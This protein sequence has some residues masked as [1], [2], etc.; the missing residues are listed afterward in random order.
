M[1]QIKPA[2][3]APSRGGGQAALGSCTC[4]KL[5]RLSRR[6]TAV[7]DRALSAA[8]MRVTQYSLLGHL[9]G[10]TGVPISELAAILDMDRTTLTRNLKS[11]LEAGWVKARSSDEDARVRL[12]QL[13]PVGEERWKAARAHWRQAQD[14]VNATIGAEGLATMHQMLDSYVRLF[15]PA[16][17]KE[18][19]SE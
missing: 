10:F 15:R 18:G 12:V 19:D 8:G 9:R 3:G 16:T 2:R 5:R 7:Y 4:F 6:V 17:G 14:E 1:P 11:L 13:T